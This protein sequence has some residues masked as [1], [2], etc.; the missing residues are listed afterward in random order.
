[1]AEVAKNEVWQN[2][3]GSS[4][5][6]IMISE[7]Q[8]S[9]VRFPAWTFNLKSSSSPWWGVKRATTSAWILGSPLCNRGLVARSGA[10]LMC[11]RESG[12]RGDG[13]MFCYPCRMWNVQATL[14]LVAELPRRFAISAAAGLFRTVSFAATSFSHI[15]LPVGDHLWRLQGGLHGCC[16]PG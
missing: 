11:A 4:R 9:L 5:S 10:S 13:F 15:S 6:D 14:W 7:K 3:N 2:K 12:Q 1:M 8:D 16:Q